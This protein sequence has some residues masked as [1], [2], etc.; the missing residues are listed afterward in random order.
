[1][2]KINDLI[3]GKFAIEKIGKYL[4]NNIKPEHIERVTQAVLHLIETEQKHH[5][6]KM[7]ISL[8]VQGDKVFIAGATISDDDK[9]QVVALQNVKPIQKGHE[10]SYFIMQL[11]STAKSIK[12][13][14]DEE[15]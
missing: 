7:V 5:N 8:I 11:L 6:D 4:L 2:S 15:F 13:D 3:S 10:L 9:Y 14:L 12:T 1:M